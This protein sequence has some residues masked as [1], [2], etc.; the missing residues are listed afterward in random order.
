MNFIRIIL[1]IISVST[2][3]QNGFHLENEKN[4][5]IRFQFVN[6]LI[7][8]PVTINGT[9][10]TFILDSGVSQTILF[11]LDD[12]EINLRN[13]KKVFFSGLG[14]GTP[15]AGFKS[16]NNQLKIGRSYT[17]S[18]HTVYTILDSQL[19]IAKHIGI[20]VNGIIGYE[21]FKNFPVE[22]NFKTKRI[23]VHPEIES[24][25]RKL[26][27]FNALPISIE[28]SKPYLLGDLG[29][30]K[31]TVHAKLLIDIGNSDALW[32][33]PLVAGNYL[34][35]HPNIEDF[36]GVGF[37][38]DIYGKRTRISGFFM[39][40]FYFNQP[41]VAI[42][43]I[44]S[45]VH[46]EKV[47]DR[48]G[49]VGNEILRRFSM[50]LDYQGKKIYLKKNNSYDEPFL[51]DKGGIIFQ[52]D[53]LSWDK[54]TIAL[55]DFDKNSYKDTSGGSNNVQFQYKYVLI[56][57]YSVSSCRLDSPCD[58]AGIKTDDKLISINGK[59][60]GDMSLQEIMEE[61]RN[62]KEDE[63]VIVKVERN[64]EIHKLKLILKNPIPYEE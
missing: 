3:A 8:I 19:D 44:E 17:D 55:E 21:F 50:V 9:E 62:G 46:L 31:K 1:I 57:K 23:I 40:E 53:G 45:L 64:G 51:T 48:S 25:G 47:K 7:F 5:I 42:P 35:D 54:E 30:N 6:N 14:S 61:F 26:K 12:K 4:A 16:E 34:T 63:T 15:I 33:F 60:A 18:K 2:F 49:S 41:L 52:H 29:L 38:G 11:N 56:P 58:K 36:L 13:A 28:N 37:N 27:K 24:M 22:I 10:L 59:R 20:P 32:I 39:S 43:D